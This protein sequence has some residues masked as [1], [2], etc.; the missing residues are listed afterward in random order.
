MSGIVDD[1]YRGCLLGLAVGDALGAPVEFSM[2]GAFAPITDLVAGGPFALEAGEWTDDTSMALCLGVSLVES[3]E[4]DPHDVMRRW[5][6]WQQ[7]GYLSSTG[8]CFDIGTTTA[9]ALREYKAAPV[10]FTGDRGKYTAGNGALMR[11][12]PLALAYA[13]DWDRAQ[14]LCEEQARLTHGGEAIGASAIL[15]FCLAALL[16]GAKKEHLSNLL[17]TRKW[18]R[19]GAELLTPALQRLVRGD[20]LTLSADHIDASGYCVDTLRAALWAFYQEE[21]YAASVLKVVNLGGDT[22]TTGAVCGAL[23]GA[24]YGATGIPSHWVER[25]AYSPAIAILASALRKLATKG[26]KFY[27]WSLTVK[28]VAQAV[29]GEIF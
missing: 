6:R 10:I 4:Y 16:C 18:T 8:R 25:T 5:L 28:P 23:C 29:N 14:L 20:Y 15:G 3:G 21:T 11:L 19:N 7:T 1:R 2:R 27:D 17:R 12:A 24:H 22:D 26:E 13:L 9:Q